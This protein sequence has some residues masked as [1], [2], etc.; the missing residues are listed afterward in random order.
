[1]ML[2]GSTSPTNPVPISPEPVGP[3]T[4]QQL[5]A[6]YHRVEAI[7]ARTLQALGASYRRVQAAAAQL[8][9]RADHAK[10]R[11][12]AILQLGA[13]IASRQEQGLDVARGVEDKTANTDKIYIPNGLFTT[14]QELVEQGAN[15]R[16]P[17]H[18][19]RPAEHRRCRP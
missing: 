17:T 9:A 7:Q 11:D 18:P 1:M 19:Q 3:P 5:S 10:A 4:N 12:R 13:D 15:N 6:A 14:L 2:A 16:L 8:E